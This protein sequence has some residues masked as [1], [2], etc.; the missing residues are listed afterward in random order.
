MSKCIQEIFIGNDLKSLKEQNL[1]DYN[2][3]YDVR[4]K[5]FKEC[6][7]VIGKDL[8]SKHGMVPGFKQHIKESSN[9][10]PM[11][12]TVT[13]TK[14]LNG[15]G[16]YGSK[17]GLYIIIKKHPDSNIGMYT[18]C[19]FEAELFEIPEELKTK[20]STTGLE[21]WTKKLLP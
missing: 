19:G 20:T 8:N 2:K 17:S 1:I 21:L 14:Y 12:F 7:K 4:L 6:Q 3:E 15:H 9:T 13:Y 16:N 10:N 18:Y 5:T 11:Y